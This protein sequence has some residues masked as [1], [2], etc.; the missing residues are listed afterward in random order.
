MKDSFEKMLI[1]HNTK[2]LKIDDKT[3]KIGLPYEEFYYHRLRA[4]GMKY[5]TIVH[6]DDEGFVEDTER[7]E[8]FV[9]EKEYFSVD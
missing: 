7:I 5:H 8:E 6:L 2:Y 3:F 1:A 4:E 9:I